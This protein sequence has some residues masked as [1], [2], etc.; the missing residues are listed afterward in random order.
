[1]L[2][3]TY[4]INTNIK[5]MATMC[6]N[7]RLIGTAILPNHSLVFKRHCDI[8]AHQG[9]QCTGVLWEIDQTVLD[10]L[11][12]FEGYPTYYERKFVE[13]WYKAERVTA[14]VYYMT[15]AHD[16]SLPSDGYFQEVREGYVENGIDTI[17]LIYAVANTRHILSDRTNKTLIDQ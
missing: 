14:M 7:A 15:P 17:Q 5:H 16:Y 6:P 11:D 13:V 2:M 3:F 1:M 8:E 4:G 9:A 10:T 12:T